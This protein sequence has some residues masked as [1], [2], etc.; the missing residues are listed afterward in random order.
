MKKDVP[1][2]WDQAYHNAYEIIKKYFAN[3]PILGAPMA[4]KTLILYIIA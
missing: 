1:F 2:V 3:Q 4:G